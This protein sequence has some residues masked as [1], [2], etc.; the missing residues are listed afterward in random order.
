MVNRFSRT[1]FQ[2]VMDFMAP[3]A[4][5]CLFFLGPAYTC[6]SSI[7]VEYTTSNEFK[8]GITLDISIAAIVAFAAS[9]GYAQC[10]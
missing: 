5:V 10:A 8:V 3:L 6:Y 4:H 7:M 1:V 2:K 9:I